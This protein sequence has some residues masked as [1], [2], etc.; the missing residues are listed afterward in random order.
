MKILITGAAGFIGYH[1]ARRLLE[2][3]CEVVGM[4]N[5]N[6]YYDIRLKEARLA[7]LQALPCFSFL[8]LDLADRQGMADMFGSQAFDV[9]LHLGAQ[10][11]V[12]HSLNDPFAYADSNLTGTLT[13]LEGCR[14]N[15][16]KHLVYAS[17][18]SVYGS[19]D[20]L[21]FSVEDR[22]DAP[23][24][25]YAATKKADELMC[26]A[27][28]HLYR[29]P[30]TGL[31]FF[32]VYGP[33]G[34]PDMAYFKF[35]DAIMNNRAIDVYNNGD[36]QRDFTYIDD[37]VDGIFSAVMQQPALSREG[38][39]HR[40]Y[41]L[42]HNHPEK[43][44]DMIGLL[45]KYLGRKAETNLLP[46]QPGDVAATYADI[47]SAQRD[48]GFIPKTSLEEGLRKFADWFLQDWHSA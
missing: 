23:I 21:P 35:A 16:I 38:L 5:L 15:G 14:H 13:V 19:N 33:W 34:R 25:L 7:R 41:N 28:A 6:D 1:S 2:A 18:S 46:M 26:H 32:T 36:M 37:I 12:R 22:V 20:K 17:S 44:L 43:L 45:E 42:G 4:D 10:A 27:Y 3:G 40:I 47:D 11:G 8:K 29:F 30:I 39:S 9:V 24:S 48:L 31:R